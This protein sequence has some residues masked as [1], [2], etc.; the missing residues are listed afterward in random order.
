MA[1]QDQEAPSSRE[2]CDANYEWRDGLFVRRSGVQHREEEYGS[3]GF[4]LLRAMQERHF[5][6]RGRHRFLRYAVHSWSHRL[7]RETRPGKLQLG[8]TVDL[9]GGCGG[10]VR[11]LAN[12]QELQPSELALADSSRRALNGAVDAMPADVSRYQVDLLDLGW[13]QRWETVFLLDVLEHIPDDER[14]LAQIYHAMTPGGL[15]FITTP[16]LRIFWTWNDDLVHHQRRYSKTDFQRLAS[17]CGYHL[18][19]A[20][21]FMFYLS[22]LLL[23]SRWATSRRARE[24]DAATQASMIAAMHQVPP[25]LINEAFAALF[26]LETPLGHWMPFPWGTS[27]LAVLQKPASSLNDV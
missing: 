11:Y 16:A 15:L 4:A 26:S 12:C 3:A 25:L 22:P 1:P 13:T 23:V 6:Y 10:W 20:R 14:V 7:K 17:A 27:I 19:S 24:P 9:G 5:W 2:L 18:L 8:R 21:Y